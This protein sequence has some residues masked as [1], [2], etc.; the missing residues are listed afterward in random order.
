MYGAVV[1]P[2][3][4]CRQMS[5]G[6]VRGSRCQ[7]QWARTRASGATSNQRGTGSGSRG[8]RRGFAQ[9]YSVIQCPPSQ[10]GRGT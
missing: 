5:V 4:P 7:W 3:R 8:K 6:R 1:E 9:V 2:S 10:P